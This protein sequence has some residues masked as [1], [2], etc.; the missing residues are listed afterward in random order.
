MKITISRIFETTKALATESG[1]ELQDFINFCAQFSE[2]TL[3]ALRNGLTYEDNMDCEARTVAVSH[4]VALPLT[5]PK[6]PKEIR[7]RRII[8]PQYALSQPLIW[9]FSNTGQPIIKCN[10]SPTPTAP[11]EIDIII[12][13]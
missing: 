3:R 10:F 2:I 12:L 8:N 6:R 13:Y 4:G 5:V 7:C 9:Y 11:V 1:Q